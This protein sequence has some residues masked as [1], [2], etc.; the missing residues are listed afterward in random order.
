M[1][2]EYGPVFNKKKY[3]DLFVIRTNKAVRETVTTGLI[4]TEYV[5]IVAGLSPG[6]SIIISDISR[7]KRKR[8]IEFKDL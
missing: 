8:E 3:Q 6:D 1:G 7:S 2:V 4:G 5:E